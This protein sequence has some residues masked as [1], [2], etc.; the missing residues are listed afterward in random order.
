VI[1]GDLVAVAVAGSEGEAAVICGYLES[2]GIEA[3]FD[4]TGVAQPF[5]IS[6]LGAAHVGRQEILV[7]AS[8]VEAALAALDARPD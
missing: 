4:K 8:D 3:T 1:D 5:A 2:E 7:R 6:G